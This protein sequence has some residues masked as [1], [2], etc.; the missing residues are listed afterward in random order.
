MTLRV[1]GAVLRLHHDV[2]PLPDG[3][4]L[5][6]RLAELL[7]DARGARRGRRRVPGVGPHPRHRASTT[8]RTTGPCSATRMNYIVNLFRSRQQDPTLAAAPFTADQLAA[9]QAGRV[10]DGPLLPPSQPPTRRP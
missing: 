3:R 10:P 2:P 5:P 8:G 6:D 4:A 7:D 9:M 1:P